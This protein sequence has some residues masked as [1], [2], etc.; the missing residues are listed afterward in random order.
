MNAPPEFCTGS[1]CTRQ[2]VSAPIISIVCSSSAR[3][4]AVNSASVSPS[5]RR[6][7]F[8]FRTFRTSGTSGS[9][10]LRIG[11]IPVS[12]SAPIVVPW[13]AVCRVIAL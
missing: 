11:G 7:R 10:G 12:E 5:G 9:N 2:T 6:Y 4:E 13:Y 8:V 3:R 1:M